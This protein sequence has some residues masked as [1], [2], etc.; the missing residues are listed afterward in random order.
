MNKNEIEEWIRAI[1]EIIECLESNNP[2]R[3][4]VLLGSLDQRMIRKFKEL[5]NGC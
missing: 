4:Y 5:D 3:G 2:I 1:R